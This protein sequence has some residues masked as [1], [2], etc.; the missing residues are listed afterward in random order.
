MLKWFLG[1]Y[2]QVLIYS[3]NRTTNQNCLS[4][5]LYSK[6]ELLVRRTI[7]LLKKDCKVVC[8]LVRKKVYHTDKGT[9]VWSRDF[10]IWKINSELWAVVW[11]GLWNKR[12]WAD[13]EQLLRPVLLSFYGQQ[14]N[15]KF[16]WKYFRVRTEKLQK[17]GKQKSKKVWKVFFMGKEPVFLGLKIWV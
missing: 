13:Y 4:F 8:I 9:D 14:I 5:L 6:I 11:A 3:N 17:K 12:V 10:I 1:R 7:D 2:L 15:L 16:F